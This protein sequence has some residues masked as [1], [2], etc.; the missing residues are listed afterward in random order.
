MNEIYHKS[1]IATSA[2]FFLIYFLFL[3][4]DSP[5]NIIFG[6]HVF[7]YLTLVIGVLTLV[8]SNVIKI[9]S[10][11]TETNGRNDKQAL[12]TII[13]ILT[14]F[15]LTIGSMITILYLIVSNKT[16][17]V[18]KQVSPSYYSFSNIAII[19][20]FMQIF[21]IYYY[22]EK[23]ITYNLLYLL[24]LLTSICGIILYTILSYFSTDG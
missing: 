23:P 3:L 2:S 19:L 1:I 24:G 11:T 18:Q 13:S 16:A 7:G 8:V 20:F 12:S 14:P 22:G 10:K 15:I 6:A 17:I 9:I 5:A 4:T 21:L